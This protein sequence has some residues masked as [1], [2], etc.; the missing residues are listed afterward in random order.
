MGRKKLYAKRFSIGLNEVQANNLENISKLMASS[1]S[2]V[3]AYLM[4]SYQLGDFKLPGK[5]PI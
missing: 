3:I 4:D 1:Y 2:E 5:K